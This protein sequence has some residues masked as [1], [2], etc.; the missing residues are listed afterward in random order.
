MSDTRT[1]SAK[2]SRR[3][4]WEVKSKESFESSLALASEISDSPDKIEKPHR[5]SKAEVSFEDDSKNNLSDSNTSDDILSSK[6][7]S[8]M[9]SV[10]KKRKTPTP[11]ENDQV[12]VKSTDLDL[13]DS[14]LSNM[15][16]NP[17]P[18][19]PPLSPIAKKSDKRKKSS[20]S[21][22]KHSK[23][24]DPNES[25]ISSQLKHL[26]EDVVNIENNNNIDSAIIAVPGLLLGQTN[27]DMKEI[28]TIY[29]ERMNGFVVARDKNKNFTLE[30]ERLRDLKKKETRVSHA[31]NLQTG[32]RTFSILCQGLLA[33]LTLAHCLMVIIFSTK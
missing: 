24:T 13:V 27:A 22:K 32:F 10:E 29:C 19:A 1:A 15:T 23:K 26:E 12:T 8:L 6:L 14:E 17:T 18:T 4:R 16:M 7:A 2:S 33:G 31:I 28:S 11:D 20:K 5:R 21:K 25:F 3:R 30:N 9:D